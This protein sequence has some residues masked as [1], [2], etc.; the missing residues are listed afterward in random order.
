VRERVFAIV[1]DFEICKILRTDYSLLMAVTYFV[2]ELS[3]ILY[4]GLR[5]FQRA[6]EESCNFV[7]D[8]PLNQQ[9]KHL[10][11]KR[12]KNLRTKV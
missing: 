10:L 3:K 2:P 9:S 7:T 11:Q 12:A 5:P 1:T 8:H 4:F 6:I